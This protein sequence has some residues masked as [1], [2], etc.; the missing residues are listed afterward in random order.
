MKTIG[1]I[2]ATII[3]VPTVLGMVLIGIVLSALP[4]ALVTWLFLVL[5]GS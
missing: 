2:I 1:N 5:F 4:I 3:T